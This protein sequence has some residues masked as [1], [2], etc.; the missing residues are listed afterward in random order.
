MSSVCRKEEPISRVRLV[1]GK[2]TE[3]V[4]SYFHKYS[5][6]IM[7]KSKMFVYLNGRRKTGPEEN[8]TVIKLNISSVDIFV[9]GRYLLRLLFFY[10][11][12]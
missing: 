12:H 8:M 2:H 9:F 11:F 1:N 10:Y 5:A 4:F 3:H 6:I 7:A